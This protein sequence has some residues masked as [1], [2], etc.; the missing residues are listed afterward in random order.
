MSAH[1]GTSSVGG[2]QKAGEGGTVPRT[3]PLYAR[4]SPWL[5]RE[6]SRQVCEARQGG[7]VNKPPPTRA[8][9]P[10]TRGCPAG[11]CRPGASRCTAPDATA[12]RANRR[13]RLRCRLVHG[14]P[15]RDA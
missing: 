14:L 4:Q 8:W 11:G 9:P 1:H 2:E 7:Q 12:R 13:C 15:C 3:G 5:V 6:L 10:G